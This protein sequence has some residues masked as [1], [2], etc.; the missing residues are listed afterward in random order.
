ML[1]LG[2]QQ[3][4]PAWGLPDHDDASV[5]P[6][7]QSARSSSPMIEPISWYI[8]AFHEAPRETGFGK[9]VGQRVVFD[10][11]TPHVV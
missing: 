2:D 8:E 6:S 3:S 5:S 9:L 1:I 11:S 4:R 7:S 10:S